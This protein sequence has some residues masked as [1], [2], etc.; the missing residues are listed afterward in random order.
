MEMPRRREEKQE[1][2]LMHKRFRMFLAVARAA[3][4]DGDRVE[5]IAARL[6]GSIFRSVAGVV[7]D[8]IMH[9][10]SEQRTTEVKMPRFCFSNLGIKNYHN[11]DIIVK[12]M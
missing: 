2:Y 6:E 11:Y 10:P 7:C 12:R 3:L 8:K 4:C 1:S 5:Q 9:L